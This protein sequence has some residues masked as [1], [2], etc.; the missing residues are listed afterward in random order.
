MTSALNAAVAR[1]GALHEKG[2]AREALDGA[3][4]LLREHPWV[5]GLYNVRGGIHASLGATVRASRDQRRALLLRPGFHQALYNHGNALER[6]GALELA[7]SQYHRAVLV[8]SGFAPAHNN[9]GSVLRDLG[10]WREALRSFDDATRADPLYAEGYFNSANSHRDL[11]GYGAADRSYRRALAL[12]PEHGEAWHHLGIA[13]QESA[14]NQLA[15]EFHRRA[16]A[17]RPDHAECHRN[18]ANLTVYAPGHPHLSVMRDLLAEPATTDNDRARLNFALAKAHDDFGETDRSFAYL[19]RGNETRKASLGYDIAQHEVLFTRIRRA[20]A[21][22]AA[23]LPPRD[24]DTVRPIFIV[25]MPRSGTTLIEQILASHPH[26]HGAGELEDLTRLAYRYLPLN[27]T[28]APSGYSTDDL[29]TLRD[30]YLDE[31]T[32]LGSGR[33]IITDKMPTNFM[34]IGVIHAVFPK[35][36]IINLKRDPRAVAWSIY[37]HYLP[38]KAHGYAYDLADIARFHALYRDLMGFWTERVPG[39]HLDLDY[40]TFT[41]DPEAGTR[42]LL[43]YCGLRWNDRC[44]DFHRAA[45]PVKTASADQVRRAVYRGSSEAWRRYASHIRATLDGSSSLG[46]GDPE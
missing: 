19:R 7:L 34:W 29:I 16:L 39:G 38:T 1:I 10:R 43:A 15:V 14:D 11:G 6:D 44:L 17:I 18:L 46:F 20:F 21:G 31:I 8:R 4:A 42:A 2:A 25:G 24:S 26:V 45:R 9:A 37:R 33:K 32:R 3:S 22:P 36:R 27:E 28:G 5:P 23:G 41:D 40:E 13:T 30:T 12:R 35:A